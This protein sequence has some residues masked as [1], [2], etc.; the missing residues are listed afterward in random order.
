MISDDEGR[1]VILAILGRNEFFGEMGLI[2]DPSPLGERGRAR[3][4]A[5]C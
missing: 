1:E 3:G 2:D 4:P 5:S